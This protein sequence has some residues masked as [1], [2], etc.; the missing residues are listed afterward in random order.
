MLTNAVGQL[1]YQFYNMKVTFL[2]SIIMFE[3]G[4]ALCGA[5]PNS[6]SFIAGRA[7]ASFAGAKFFS[8]YMLVIIPMV[9]LHMRPKFQELFRMVFGVLGPLVGGGFT[10]TI[11]WR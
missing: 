9:P 1:M 7:I 11:S 3:A 6:R 4:S 10:E 8:G 2:A 5:A